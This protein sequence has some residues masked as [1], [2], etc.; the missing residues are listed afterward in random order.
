MVFAVSGAER[1]MKVLAYIGTSLALLVLLALAPGSPVRSQE[2]VKYTIKDVM[3]K[4][5]KNKLFEKVGK[6]MAT[7]IEKKELVELYTALPLN[8]PPKGG[9]KAWKEKTTK[10][11]ELARG[12]LKDDK[13]A[14][15]RL[16]KEAGACNPCHKSFRD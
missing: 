14:G 9:E 1:S 3:E 13:E 5:H 4:A 8:K 11:L 2:K 15:A 12:A 6:G 10:M 16:L 7:E